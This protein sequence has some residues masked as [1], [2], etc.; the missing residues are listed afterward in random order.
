MNA[1]FVDTN[2]VI[3]CISDDQ[4]KRG[5]ALA[6][7][8]TRPVL[9]A[10]VLNETA[11]TMKRKLRFEPAEISAVLLRLIQECHVVPITADTTLSALNIAERYKFSIYD[12]LIIAAALD[13][14]CTTLYSED[15]QHRQVIENQL[16]IVNPFLVDR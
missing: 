10:Q 1:N 5:K 13:A 7:L 4:E 9:S 12:S 16:T 8:T 11:H 6:L 14:D 15:M 3:Y 2:V